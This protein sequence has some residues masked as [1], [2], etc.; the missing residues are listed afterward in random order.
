MIT[1][2]SG[3]TRQSRYH[4]HGRLWEHK[5]NAD[6]LVRNTRQRAALSPPAQQRVGA[7]REVLGN[8]EPAGV[9]PRVSL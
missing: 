2:G 9:L 8:G 7:C 5:G 1:E 3:N 6:V 4:D